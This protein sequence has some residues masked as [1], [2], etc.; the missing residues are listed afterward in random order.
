MMSEGKRSKQTRAQVE[1]AHKKRKEK[2]VKAELEKRKKA[3]TLATKSLKKS[4]KS[5]EDKFEKKIEELKR[6]GKDVPAPPVWC[7]CVLSLGECELLYSNI[8][9]RCLEGQKHKGIMS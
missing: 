3:Y 9:G 2:F 8:F 7:F 5:L 4:L 1:K 6:K